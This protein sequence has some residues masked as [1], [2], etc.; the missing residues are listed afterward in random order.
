MGKEDEQVMRREE[1][2]AGG[3][4]ERSEAMAQIRRREGVTREEVY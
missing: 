4:S 1:R 3:G 2:R